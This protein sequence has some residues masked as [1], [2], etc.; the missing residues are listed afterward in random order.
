MGQDRAV[1]LV[2]ATPAIYSRIEGLGVSARVW[3]EV[4]YEM[5][6]NA[7]GVPEAL[8]WLV[9]DYRYLAFKKFDYERDGESDHDYIKGLMEQAQDVAERAKLQDNYPDDHC[10]DINSFVRLLDDAEDDLL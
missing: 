7:V 4:L 10:S 8:R 1:R 3:D 5:Y 2:E 6:P 9:L